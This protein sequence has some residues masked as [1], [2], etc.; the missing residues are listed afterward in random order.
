MGMKMNF[1]EKRESKTSA[2]VETLMSQEVRT[3]RP[4]DSLHF[5]ARL[6]WDHD[7]GCVP[8]VDE[9]LVIGMLTD[10]DICMAAYMQGRSLP[11][12]TVEGAMSKHVYFCHPDDLLS[13][14]EQIMAGH[15]V[16]RLPVLDKGGRL[17]GILSLSDLA[18]E[19]THTSRQNGRDV[20]RAEIGKTLI[21]I[22]GRESQGEAPSPA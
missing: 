16:R 17:V 13:E 11:E 14:A 6:M 12:L 5:A 22:C 15:R 4:T 2:K 19:A 3:C 9:N 8:I 21:A 7:C 18:R 10:R 1:S 20:T